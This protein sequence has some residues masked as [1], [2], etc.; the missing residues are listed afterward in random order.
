VAADAYAQRPDAAKASWIK[1]MGLT[2]QAGSHRY[3]PDVNIVSVAAA[4]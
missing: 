3:A 2:R 1:L 4:A